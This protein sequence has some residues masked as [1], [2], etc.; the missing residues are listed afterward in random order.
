MIEQQLISLQNRASCRGL[1]TNG[2]GRAAPPLSQQTLACSSRRHIHVL[3][4]FCKPLN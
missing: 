3:E 2:R 4:R 1:Q